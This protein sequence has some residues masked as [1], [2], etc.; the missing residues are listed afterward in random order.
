VAS[1]ARP[2]PYSP[3]YLWAVVALGFLAIAESLLRLNQVPLV[4][5][6]AQWSL[7]A[8][9]TLVLVSGSASVQIPWA[10]VS[11][12]ISEAFVFTVVLLYGPVAG[13]LTVALDCLVIS[14]WIARRRPQLHRALFNIAAPVLSAW[15]SAHLFF[16]V[17]GIDPL[18]LRPLPETTK[19]YLLFYRILPSLV[20][21][22][23]TYFGLNSWL[24]A[25][26]VAHEKGHAPLHVWRTGFI[27]L[28]L[29]YFC[30]ASVAFLWIG[31]SVGYNHPI[32][33][34]FGLVIVPLLLVLY[35]T[36]KTTM[37]RVE[38]ANRHVEQLN[39]LYL[40][41]IETLAMAIDAK[42]QITHGHIRRV[43]MFAVGLAKR[44]GVADDKLIK[45]IEAAALL[46]DMGKLAVPE[47][48]LNKPGKLTVTEF[49]KMKLHASVG[50]DIL[51]AIDFPY[52]VVPIVR[53]HHE[54]WDGSGYPKGLKGTDIPI[55]ARILS[56][57]DCFDALTSDRPYRPRLSDDDAI[58]ILV[59]RR[60]TM[61][62]PLVVDTFLRVHTDIAPQ[63]APATAS[64]H[65]L[66][67]MGGSVRSIALVEK[68]SRLDE[69][70][71]SADEML[72]LYELARGLAGQ[73]SIADT[74]DII[75]KHLRR[76]VPSALCVFYLY[77]PVGDELEAKHVMGD[78]ASTVRGLK[79][80]L[81]QRLSGWVAANRQTIIN[82]DPTLD[83]GDVARRVTP[84]LRS[85]LSTPLLSGETLVG[86][87]TL[88][89]TTADGYTEDHRRI[90]EAVARQIGHTFQSA[91]GFD[92][93][94]RRDSLTG[95]PNL[96]HL[97]D[98]LESVS[99]GTGVPA[100]LL[101]IEVL[102]VKQI[103]VLNGRSIGDR[104]L[105][106]VVKHARAALRVGDILFRY[107]SDGFV[108]L[109]NDA[110]AETASAV[111]RRIGD[112]IRERP[113][114]VRGGTPITIEAQV[115]CVSAPRDGRS[116]RA[117][118]SAARGL[119]ATAPPEPDDP[120]VH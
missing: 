102:G 79:I 92:K 7:L 49:E 32:K 37:Q 78:A 1:E 31:L 66:R 113:L 63:I 119:S 36:F 89:S 84:R 112:D 11:I 8:L 120:T 104:V 88:Y 108:A 100:S 4:S 109:L 111:A 42:D 54:N 17:S 29:N 33:F 117:L 27:W 87:L 69:I 77:D 72:T 46:H 68:P 95:L 43:Q 53:H 18:A 5:Q 105:R 65:I 76:L 70:A 55:G 115:T 82:S 57:V 41:T 50:A 93:A 86:V 3:A 30:G 74:G 13:T 107:G 103:R 75:A 47:Y 81:A 38:D 110:D 9:L 51:S 40:S 118:M 61:Y 45:A 101:L 25:F 10:N 73:A 6:S 59:E 52:P 94:A 34:W 114:P 99:V 97:E 19:E 22:A 67:K 12:S 21:F 85:C 24:I 44:V 80:P 60:G 96:N 2:T 91:E 98:L 56:V 26:A 23:F 39:N 106:Q 62:D 35:F 15:C 116:L 20:L 16:Y 71:A 83:L 28:S 58:R 14:F 48:I 64:G 90:V